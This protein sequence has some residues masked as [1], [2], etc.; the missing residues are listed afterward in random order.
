MIFQDKLKIWD[1]GQFLSQVTAPGQKINKNK[2]LFQ[3]NK[4]FKK[5]INFLLPLTK[6][7]LF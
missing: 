2:W 1:Q 5:M 3:M 6:R 4:E 7:V